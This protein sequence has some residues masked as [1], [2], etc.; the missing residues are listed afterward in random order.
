MIEAAV[1]V[2]DEGKA[3]KMN[4][5]H[6]EHNDR[7]RSC[8]EVHE[9]IINLLHCY[10]NKGDEPSAFEVMSVE[11]ALPFVKG[12]MDGKTYESYKEWVDRHKAKYDEEIKHYFRL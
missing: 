8:N 11:S 5:V 4:L 3:K 2:T 9:V 10:N 7:T 6:G 12:H 1:A